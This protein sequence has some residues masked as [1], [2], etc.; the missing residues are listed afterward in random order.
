M[1]TTI[2]LPS[3][4]LIYSDCG[5]SEECII[6]VIDKLNENTDIDTRDSFRYYND[7]LIIDLE[8]N[9]IKYNFLQQ[10][11]DTNSFVN[12]FYEGILDSMHK[13]KIG[14]KIDKIT[15]N[16]NLFGSIKITEYGKISDLCFEKSDV[17]LFKKSINNLL[18]T[19][20]NATNECCPVEN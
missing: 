10:N 15:T 16:K 20:N 6:W 18:K 13:Y 7:E 1:T 14:I 8:Y 5:P 2:S 11:D 12:S 9:L 4:Y 17:E 3:S 19:Y